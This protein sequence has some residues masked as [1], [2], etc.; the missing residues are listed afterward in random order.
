[1]A[2]NGLLGVA[3]TTKMRRERRWADPTEIDAVFES[4]DAQGGPRAFT[5]RCPPV[6]KGR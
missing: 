5:E 3:I 6:W 4:E 2:A 1:M